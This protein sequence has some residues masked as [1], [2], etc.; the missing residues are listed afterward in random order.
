MRIGTK[1]IL[2]FLVVVLIILVPIVSN[3]MLLEEVNRYST[4]E[5]YAYELSTNIY[6]EE[7]AADKYVR[8]AAALEEFE[9]E[10]NNEGAEALAEEY[11]QLRDGNLIL[12]ERLREMLTTD[13][14]KAVLSAVSAKH[15]G[16]RNLFEV[17]HNY[18]K[19]K[20]DRAVNQNKVGREIAD[21]RHDLKLVLTH[22]DYSLVF[23]EDITFY[24]PASNE[25]ET[26][27]VLTL[28]RELGYKEKEYVWQYKD[29]KHLEDVV[30]V[31]T[32]LEAT[33]ARSNASETIRDK[34][35]S[36]LRDY[37]NYTI[38]YLGLVEEN[39]M[40]RLSALESQYCR[41]LWIL[42][43]EELSAK[44]LYNPE[45]GDKFRQFREINVRGKENWVSLEY[46][47]FELGHH[48]KE[49]L[50]Q[51]DGRKTD[52][53]DEILGTYDGI[54][55]LVRELNLS[56]SDIDDILSTLAEHR[57]ELEN[58][59]RVRSNYETVIS[60][61]RQEKTVRIMAMREVANEIQVGVSDLDKEGL[62]YIIDTQKTKTN[63]QINTLITSN[64]IGGFFA[65]LIAVIL[66]LF[67]SNS[68]SKP[69]TE[70]KDAS[71]RIGRGNLNTKIELKSKDEIGELA[72]AFNQM[73]KGLKESREKLE[74][75]TRALAKSKGEV[76]AKMGELEEFNRITFGREMKIVELK[77][78]I[79][80][81]E[82]ELK[83][84]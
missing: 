12:T 68:I 34:A 84:K 36:S 66:G 38:D 61:A 56:Q 80:E 58:F 48:E 10:E 76:E 21:A 8:Q 9:I 62:D 18:Y 13:E 3:W 54:I 59:M 64:L 16:L 67:I 19:N 74:E 53:Y 52:H 40:D 42:R 57:T 44:Y 65:V 79:E 60:D 39:D 24:C 47:L 31:I 82:G 71:N 72:F 45:Y 83:S 27:N 73:T 33:I 2:G 15:R 17:N 20:L 41:V 55:S 30:H 32:D 14:E 70:L 81:L 63:Q 26:K 35:L 51:D 22:P 7:I 1:L 77:K 75:Q 23:S 11:Y 25:T 28:F 37:K 78:R 49:I 69:I 43:H 50:F 29:R 5:K 46:L 6:L 4:A